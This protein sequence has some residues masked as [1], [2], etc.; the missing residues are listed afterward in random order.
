MSTNTSLSSIHFSQ[1]ASETCREKEEVNFYLSLPD[2]SAGTPVSLFTL[3]H[4]KSDQDCSP[5]EA[6]LFILSLNSELVA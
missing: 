3:M 6:L 2:Q 1:N 5:R 4:K